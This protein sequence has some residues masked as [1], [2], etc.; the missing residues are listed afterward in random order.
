MGIYP[1]N[2]SVCWD[3]IK[4]GTYPM[5]EAEA[6]LHAGLLCGIEP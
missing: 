3:V 5:L 2:P 6:Y 1:H 4:P